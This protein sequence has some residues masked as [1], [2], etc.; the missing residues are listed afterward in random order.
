LFLDLSSGLGMEKMARNIWVMVTAALWE[1][2]VKKG[3]LSL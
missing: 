3:K 1:G 2:G